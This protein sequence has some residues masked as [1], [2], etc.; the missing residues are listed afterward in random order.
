MKCSIE[1]WRLRV[2]FPFIFVLKYIVNV[3]T[4]YIDIILLSINSR[5]RFQNICKRFLEFI[6]R[7]IISMYV[8]KT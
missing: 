7:S 6:E 3:L 5:K 8:V 4:T 1:D 2:F